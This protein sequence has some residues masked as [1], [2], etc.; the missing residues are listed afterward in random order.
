MARAIGLVAERDHLS[1]EAAL[2]QVTAVAPRHRRSLL[3]ATVNLGLQITASLESISL[4]TW[5]GYR[6]AQVPAGRR[7]S[8]GAERVV[9]RT[10][11]CWRARER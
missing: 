8:E 10:H 3:S 7:V 6:A 5:C 11:F 2:A 9:E 4:F 1:P